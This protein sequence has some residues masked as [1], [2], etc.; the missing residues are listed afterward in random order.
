MQIRNT[1]LVC[2]LFTFVIICFLFIPFSQS[3][4]GSGSQTVSDPSL[5]LSPDKQFNYAQDLF[6]AKDYLTAVNE[7][8]RFI[9]FFPKD[10]RVELAMFQIGQSY[11]LGRQFD[12]AVK[13]F[14][15]L[16]EKYF[17]TE[18]SIKSYF[19]ISE[20]YIVL[21]AFDLA[22]INLN[23]LITITKDENIRD[24]AYYR[25]GWIYIETASWDNARHYFEK[26]SP[27]N[28]N[29]FKL[30]KL[31]DELEKKALIPQKDPKLAGF[32]SIIPGGGYLYCE[33]YQDALIA[34]LLNGG[35]ILAAYE[36]FDKGHGALGGLLTFVGFGFYAG[37]IYGAV[38]SAHKFNRKETGQFIYQLKKNA[39]VNLSADLENKSVCLSFRFSF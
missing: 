4:A 28:R 31:A 2:L 8:K 19:K 12:E 7:Y 36:S 32:L 9:Y 30:K 6:S 33:R 20:I 21:K 5:I 11:F 1:N 27:K 18:Y 14:K 29:K 15:T 22:L 26:I 25:I 16:T 17:E 38:T 3:F 13:S 35:L 10:E 34:F 39:R 37:N 23:N 24:E